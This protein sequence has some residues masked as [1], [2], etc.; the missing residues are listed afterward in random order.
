MSIH[1]LLKVDTFFTNLYLKNSHQS[2]SRSSHLEV[3]CEKDLLKNIAK[4]TGK[5]LRWSLSLIK[6]QAFRP[7][8]LLR[9]TQTQV[10]SCEYCKMFEQLS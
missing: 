8:T 9:K 5:Q 1:S 4:V 2:K 7:A 3:L 6:F 10:L